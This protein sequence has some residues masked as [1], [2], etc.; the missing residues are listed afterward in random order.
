VAALLGENGAG[1]STLLK[2]LAGIVKPRAGSV[3]L[4][5]E[6]FHE[7]PRRAR[8]RRVGYLPQGF[9]PLF[10]MTALDLVLLG[11]TPWLP[12]LSGPARADREAAE[13]ALSELDA[14]S[15]AATDV[16]EMSGGERQRVLL[17]RVFAGAPEVLLLDEPT[18]N[19]DPRHRIVVMRALE[20]RAGAGATIVFSTHELDIAAACA[21]TAVLLTG[22]RVLAA[23]P[24]ATTLTAPLL[25]ELF[26]VPACVT[27][28]PGGRPVV[29]LAASAAPSA[30]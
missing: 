14:A 4:D 12:A 11:R 26:G 16:R 8:A 7:V 18:A 24:V 9:E 13:A 6:D 1:K 2:A 3:R 30:R 27:P 15:F 20:R 10:P 23:G 19:L 21:D 29:T 22:G 28:V 25:T 5:G 17:A